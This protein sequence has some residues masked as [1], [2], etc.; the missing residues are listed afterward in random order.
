[1]RFNGLYVR[2]VC[3]FI[4]HIH[5][6][7]VLIECRRSTR[8]ASIEMNDL[9]PSLS[10]ISFNHIAVYVSGNFDVLSNNFFFPL[11]VFSA[12]RSLSNVCRVWRMRC[13]LIESR[14]DP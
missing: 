6:L 1:M 13:D 9:H 12:G 4:F 3:L 8:N 10:C 5:L 14:Q 11:F 2:P 7:N